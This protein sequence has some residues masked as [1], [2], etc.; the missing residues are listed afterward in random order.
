M[1]SYVND[2]DAISGLQF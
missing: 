2:S 1:I